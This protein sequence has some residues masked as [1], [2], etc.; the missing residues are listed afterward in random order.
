MCGHSRSRYTE[1]MP[2]DRGLRASDADRE[3]VVDVLR[4][5]AGEGRL[6]ADE[7][8]QRLEAAYSARTFAELDALTA[9]LPRRRSGT[10]SRPGSERAPQWQP[11]ALVVAALL[12]VSVLVGHPALWL[13]FPLFILVRRAG[14]APRWR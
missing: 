1:W 10:P 4:E 12:A 7:L 8:E 5:S 6:D 2:S 13:A 14:S 3:Q 11:L 9:D